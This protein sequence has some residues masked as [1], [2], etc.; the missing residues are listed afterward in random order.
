MESGN[1]T[2]VLGAS[3]AGKTTLLA[4]ISQRTRGNVTGEISINNI[5]ISSDEMTKLSAFVPQ[6]DISIKSLTVREHLYFMVWTF[7]LRKILTV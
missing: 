4:A 3:G 6:F 5:P 2:A 1:L 7:K